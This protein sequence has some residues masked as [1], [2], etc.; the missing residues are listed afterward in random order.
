MPAEEQV[1][2]TSMYK[3][4]EFVCGAAA[5][6]TN[7]IVTFPIN[8][9]MF[10]QQL[11]GISL[12]KS[13]G[14]LHKEGIHRL[15]RG[16]LPPLAQKTASMS[17]MF[18]MYDHYKRYL[19]NTT[20]WSPHSSDAAAAMIAG[21]IEAML[22]PLERIQTLMQD[23][24]Y[25]G[26][27]RNTL[28]AGI[29]IR[30]YGFKEYYRGLSC[31]LLR[32]GPS[33]VAFFLCRKP[34][35]N[36]YGVSPETD[37]GNIFLDFLSGAVLGATISTVFYPL[38]VVKTRMQSRLGGDFPGMIVT[39]KKVFKERNSSWSKMFRGVHVNFTRSLLSWGIINAS[40]E[41]YRKSLSAKT[42]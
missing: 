27:F 24:K 34:L 42:E 26:H 21:T 8:K 31:I 28:H 39:F 18:G 37:I 11:H 2:G 41:I 32:N 33:N 29:E 7:I 38:N 25:H 13:I 23:R 17:I 6:F 1:P 22:C 9:L 15:Y 30:A 35:K 16:L 36:L 4:S 14:Q 19:A 40:Y 5:A 12:Y 10:R 3:P 20:S